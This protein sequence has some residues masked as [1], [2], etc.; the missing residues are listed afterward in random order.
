M[1]TAILPS[2]PATIPVPPVLWPYQPMRISVERFHELITQGFFAENERFELLE[3]VIAEKLTKHPPHAYATKKCYAMLSKMLAA[4]WHVISQDPITLSTS[5][6]E[7]D[8]AVIQGLL[9]DFTARHPGSG[10]IPLV[11]E[12]SEST[13]ATDRYKAGIYAAAG[14]PIYWIVNLTERVV[15]VYSLPGEVEQNHAYAA[16]RLFRG[17][18]AIP[19]QL[20]GQI[21][22]HIRVNELIP[23]HSS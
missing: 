2:H 18:E 22:G 15:E 17:D 23:E 19:V 4:P 13:L 10:E 3:G 1:A 14:I 9:E 16:Q 5:E 6:P 11:V 21:V 8:I 7:P 20:A 12:V